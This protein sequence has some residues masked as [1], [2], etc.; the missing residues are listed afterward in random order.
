MRMQTIT[1]IALLMLVVG[2]VAVILMVSDPVII[3]ETTLCGPGG[4][5]Y[6]Y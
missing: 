6:L 5:A 1:L 3:S 2:C 4:C